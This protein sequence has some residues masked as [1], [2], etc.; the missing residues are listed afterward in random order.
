MVVQGHNLLKIF[1]YV[2][3]EIVH[4]I[5]GSFGLVTAAPLT[6]I[7]SGFLLTRG[8]E[9]IKYKPERMESC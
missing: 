9:E 7:T 5:V 3:A 2:A 1:L 6:A 8:E 4:A